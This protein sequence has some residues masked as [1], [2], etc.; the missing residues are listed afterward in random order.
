LGLAV[1]LLP[2]DA[3]FGLSRLPARI[4]MDGLHSRQ[5]DH[6]G[7]V[8]YCFSGYA[9][10]TSPYRNQQ[11]VLSRETDRLHDIGSAGALS[12]E[13]GVAIDHG[14]P[15]PTRLVIAVVFGA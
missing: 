12:D 14:V 3:G 8:V 10:P 4:D 6:K 5:V 2:D 15:H 1:K 13:R 11:I 7:I 9:M